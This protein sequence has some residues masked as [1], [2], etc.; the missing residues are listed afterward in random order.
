MACDL[1][2]LLQQVKTRLA[3]HTHIPGPTASPSIAAAFTEDAY[4][5]ELLLGKLKVIKS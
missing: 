4:V 2:D 5:A 1:F 3:A